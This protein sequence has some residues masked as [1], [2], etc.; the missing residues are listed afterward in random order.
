MDNTRY[1]LI[2]SADDSV[3]T[4][5]DEIQA[6]REIHQGAV[7]LHD[8]QAYLVSALDVEKKRAVAAPVRDD[9]YTVP[10]SST[11]ITIIKEQ[12]NRGVGRTICGFGD[13]KVTSGVGGYKKLQFHNH[14]N[15]GY[16]A[17]DPPLTK[18]YD[19]EGAWIHLPKEVAELFSKLEPAKPS[20]MQRN[21][22]KTYFDGLG[23]AI[24]N[25]AM[26]STMTTSEDVGADRVSQPDT[27]HVSSSI[28]IYDMFVGGLG[29]SEK[30]YDL[31]GTIIHN[32]IKMVEGCRCK[33]GCAACI[34]DHHLDK[35]VVLW[36]LKSI[37]EKLEP[38]ADVKRVEEPGIEIEQK[39]FSLEDIEF[40]WEEFA[41]FFHDRGESMSNFITSVKSVKKDSTTLVLYVDNSFFATW[42]MEEANRT[43][44]VNSISHYVDVPAQFSIRAESSESPAGE[45]EEKIIRRYQDLNR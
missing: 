42:I 30:A 44:L 6:F 41:R 43:K 33:D 27:D 16:E 23:F 21:Y 25:A 5:M 3:I 17:I 31:I 20:S 45:K 12:K 40:R 24:Q 37:F 34:G 2:N 36:G 7:Y 9:Y 39:P 18:S 14:Q 19:T 13:V 22:W 1:Q 11:G 26:M 8:G 10:F 28:C 32:A 4:E 29:Y 15:L 38:P 35:R